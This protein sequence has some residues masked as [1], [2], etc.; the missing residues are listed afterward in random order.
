MRVGACVA[1]IENDHVLL[2]KRKDFDVW[3]LPG[4]LVEENETV[5]QAALREMYE[6]TGL[7]VEITHLVGVYSIPYAKAWVNLIL[8]FAAHSEGKNL[9]LQ[10]SEVAEAKY[11]HKN[12]IPDNLLWGHR[13]RIK[14]ALGGK[15][16]T[17]WFQ[18]IPYDNVQ[19]RAEL[20]AIKQAS[21]LSNLEF[22]EQYFGFAD[23][24][25][26]SAELPLQNSK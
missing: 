19:D 3:C 25:N 7:E 4:G 20:Y 9:K 16:G 14:D 12:A 26:D 22:Y 10:E 8:T 17:F 23:H 21:G 1:I 6:E 24:K 18:N 11:F 15:V 5:V 13:Q 2:T